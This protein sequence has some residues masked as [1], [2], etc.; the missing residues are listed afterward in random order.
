MGDALPGWSWGVGFTSR[1]AWSLGIKCFSYF[2][3]K[4]KTLWWTAPAYKHTWSFPVTVGAMRLFVTKVIKQR[5]KEQNKIL[6]AHLGWSTI[7]MIQQSW[8]QLDILIHSFCIWTYLAKIYFKFKSSWFDWTDEFD[9]VTIR[10]GRKD[11]PLYTGNL[12]PV[13]I[14]CLESKVGLWKIGGRKKPQWRTNR[15]SW[16][17][18]T[19]NERDKHQ[20]RKGLLFDLP[21]VFF[22]FFLSFQHRSGLFT[23]WSSLSCYAL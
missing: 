3:H 8:L 23:L 6:Q 1:A 20:S 14:R 12:N 18:A 11:A 7:K 21:E 4:K 5:R 19:Q 15:M 9:A 2:P 17:T 13:G 10:K 22:L 16:T